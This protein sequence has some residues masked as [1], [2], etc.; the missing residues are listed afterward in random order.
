M[1]E[2]SQLIKTIQEAHYTPIGRAYIE[3]EHRAGL[4]RYIKRHKL[5]PE[6]AQQLRDDTTINPVD[7]FRRYAEAFARNLEKGGIFVY[8][9]LKRTE[10]FGSD[11]SAEPSI[12]DL[13][14]GDKEGFEFTFDFV[15]S[16]SHNDSRFLTF[17]GYEITVEPQLAYLRMSAELIPVMVSSY[18]VLGQALTDIVEAEGGDPSVAVKDQTYRD[19]AYRELCAQGTKEEALRS[20][21]EMQAR[22]DGLG[23]NLDKALQFIAN[24][25]AVN[26][27]QII[28][29]V[30]GVYVEHTPAEPVESP[31]LAEVLPKV[32]KSA[33][34][35]SRRLVKAMP[36]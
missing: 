11:E 32:R 14:H 34:A 24:V 9:D 4:E 30:E 2:S 29:S 17:E 10:P 21:K 15:D 19:R 12:F 7:H 28:S 35:R 18:N 3:E 8:Y 31:L 5:E 25:V 27:W 16:G 36:D 33:K 6:A 20:L 22:V 13:L 1:P 26:S 23:K